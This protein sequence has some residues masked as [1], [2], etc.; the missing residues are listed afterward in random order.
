MVLTNPSAKNDLEG[1]TKPLSKGALGVV[2]E[3]VA[4][5]CRKELL[6]HPIQVP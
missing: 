5:T 3:R 4:E 6:G 2:L 1:E